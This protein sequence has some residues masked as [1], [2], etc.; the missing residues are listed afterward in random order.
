MD[1]SLLINPA[2]WSDPQPLAAGGF[3]EPLPAYPELESHVLFQTS[4]ST[5]TPKWIALSKSALLLSAACVNRHLQ[6]GENSRWGLALPLHH[7]GGFGV[8]ARS[9]EAAC[10]MS[11]FPKRWDA[12]AFH[13]WLAEKRITHTSLVPTQM[14]D[15]VVA[16][17][18]APSFLKAI[19]V[20]GGR[21]VES[22]GAAARALG[23]PVLASY[24]MTEACSQ[25]A[26]QSPDLLDM[27]Y[28][29]GSIPVLGIWN[30][31][32]G[33]DGILEISGPALFSGALVRSGG[34]WNYAVRSS[35][36]HR[37]S[38][39]VEIT[40]RTLSPLGRADALAKVLGEL[41]D[42]EEIERELMG[43][44]DG[45]L[46]PGT[47]AVVAVPDE[48]TE[49]RLLPVFE[50]TIDRNLVLNVLTRYQSHALGYRRLQ[51]PLFAETI[52]RNELGKIQRA[53]LRKMATG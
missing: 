3:R 53:A 19:V 37:T 41:V 47:F 29:T 32:S 9:F 24:G 22:Q 15:L 36:W 4:G 30:V 42:P 46:L 2:F 6:V 34:R 51:P 40:G 26:T 38:D 7:V 50:K 52:P 33:E 31:R 13:A 35:D 5:G 17:L 49:H 25:I 18:R 11:I 48:R 14:H 23:W 16:G 21:L 44:S 8:A 43:F 10:G 27:P 39:R 12:T 20:G 28:Q 1:A 45:M